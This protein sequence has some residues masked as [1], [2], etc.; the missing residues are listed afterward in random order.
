MLN[1]FSIHPAVNSTD[2][3]GSLQRAIRMLQKLPALP[4][5]FCIVQPPL[6]V[7]PYLG[8]SSTPNHLKRWLWF[9]LSE[10]QSVSQK[11]LK[12]SQP[13]EQRFKMTCR[14][15][16]TSEYNHRLK[17]TIKLLFSEE[18]RPAENSGLS[19]LP[20][21]LQRN[22]NQFLLYRVLKKDL[23]FSAYCKLV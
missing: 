9:L 16:E 10:L 6:P 18:E 7:S 2:F 19:P 4:L 11:T 21:R 1:I 13:A 17:T 20:S 22:R 23:P 15:L 14:N 8:N 5:V 3:Q 12:H